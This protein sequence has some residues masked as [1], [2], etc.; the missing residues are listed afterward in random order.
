MNKANVTNSPAISKTLLCAIA[1]SAIVGSIPF[2]AQASG[3]A[4]TSFNATLTLNAACTVSA[5]NMTFSPG[6]NAQNNLSAVIDSTSNLSVL[7]TNT[8][9]YSVSLGAGA[10]GTILQ[11]QL[12]SGSVAVN[13]NLYADAVHSIIWGDGATAGSVVGLN[14]SAI[15]TGSTVGTGG[16]GTG[17]PQT[18]TVYGEVATQAA[19]A[20]GTYTDNIAVVVN[21]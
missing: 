16:V 14:G 18:L 21:F 13:Y 6:S 20:P 5:E 17:N 10:N 1:A 4:N 9:P 15:N 12:K 19:P 11:R 2:V 3:T 7:C 8:T